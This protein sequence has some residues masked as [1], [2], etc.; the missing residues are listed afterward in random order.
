M[1]KVT[2]GDLTFQ[3]NGDEIAE[4]WRIAP[5]VAAPELRDLVAVYFLKW[6][7]EALKAGPRFAQKLA[8][9]G[10]YNF[11]IRP[12]VGTQAKSIE[13]IRGYWRTYSTV[14]WAHET[15]VA[16]LRPV[17]RRRLA[18]P[19]GRF[20]KLST[21]QRRAQGIRTP[22]Q[23][24]RKNPG[25]KFVAL[26]RKRK[27]A[28]RTVLARPTGQTLKSGKP[29]LEVVFVLVP[30]VVLKPTLKL[31]STWDSLS[32]Y[33]TL[34]MRQRLDKITHILATRKFRRGE[35]PSGLAA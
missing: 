11:G 27:G 33:R 22:E 15:G 9:R 2:S 13:D 6:R 28:R 20:A 17:H 25:R 10:G 32:S 34:R 8:K 31:M 19:V 5:E 18:V 21:P 35:K 3:T 7:K 4:L 14:V 30:S 16:D 12:K 1:I 23:W 26:G 29:K 24:N